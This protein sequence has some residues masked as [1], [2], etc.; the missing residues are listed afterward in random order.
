M[1]FFLLTLVVA[2]YI[3]VLLKESEIGI[4]QAGKKKKILLSK[5]TLLGIKFTNK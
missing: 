1:V 3:F 2:R 4:K 5:E